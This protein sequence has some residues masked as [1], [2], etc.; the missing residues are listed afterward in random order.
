MAD[1]NS[2]EL[3]GDPVVEINFLVMVG[4]SESCKTHKIE[5]NIQGPTIDGLKEDFTDIFGIPSESQRWY[6]GER[7]LRDQQT[8]LQSGIEVPKKTTIIV[9]RG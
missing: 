2:G 4:N 8:L 7:L 6:I 9:K 1:G 3:E 5:C